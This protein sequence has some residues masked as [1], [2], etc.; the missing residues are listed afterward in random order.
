VNFLLT[1]PTV[2]I[3]IPILI[4]MAVHIAMSIVVLV[5]SASIF[6]NGWPDSN[7]CRRW[8]PPTLPNHPYQPLPETSECLKAKND[9]RIMMGVSGGV[10]ILIG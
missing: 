10:G 5:F 6:G 9:L 8:G 4:N 1:T 2:F 7:I 3:Q